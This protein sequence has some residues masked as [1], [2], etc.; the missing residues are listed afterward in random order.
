[1]NYRV[2][3]EKS[4]I[5]S[6]LTIIALLAAAYLCWNCNSEEKT[7]T[8]V[9]YTVFAALFSWIYLIYYLIR[10]VILKHEC[11]KKD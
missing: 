3:Y 7:G 2:V 6:I 10:R 11:I 1:M 9:V 8:R 4:P 5:A